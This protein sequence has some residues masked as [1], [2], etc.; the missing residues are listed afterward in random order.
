ME[1]LL[2][3]AIAVVIL[4][5][6]ITIAV[7]M[8]RLKNLEN[9]QSATLIK[10]DIDTLSKDV[11]LL[12]DS[13]TDKLSLKMDQNQQFVSQ[14]MQRQFQ[15]SARIIADISTRLS[16]LDET[17][18]RVV[19]VA[20]ELKT[21]QNVLQNPKQRGVLGEYFLQSV[22]ENVLPPERFTLQHKFKDGEIVDAC[23]HLEK[24]KMLP[25]DSK[26]SLENYNRLVDEKDKTKRELLARQIRADLKLRIDETSKYIRPAEG[27]MDF[28]FM[29]IPSEAVYYDLLIN[30]VGVIGAGS[31]D[32]IE[33]AF[34]DRHVIIVSPTSFMAYLQTV[35]QGLRSLQIEEQA[36]D[37]QV[38][39]G[40]LGRHL[41]TY[42]GLMQK[43]GNS[44]GTTVNHFNNAHKELKKVDKDIIKIAGTK[45]GVEP[46][47][48][49]RPVNDEP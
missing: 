49:D 12:K 36:K 22:L 30:K 44:L 26:F 33:Y 48:I 8:G 32:L 31:R 7:L 39:V 45:P 25:V 43:L 15:Q 24:K 40:Q 5:F 13:L 1:L 42:D 11:L 27:T 2:F 14:T 35:L 10:Q 47:V 29:F 41:E 37:I 21:L 23:I 46:V 6:I 16:K 4:G 18:R 34:R 20:D 38:R 17:N 28:A 3:A 19:D 9:Q